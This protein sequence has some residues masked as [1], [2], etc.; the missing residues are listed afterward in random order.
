MKNIFL[1]ILF[2][3]FTLNM[4]LKAQSAAALV[5]ICVAS[6][7][8]D[9]TYLK[10][11]IIELEA[12][13]PNEKPP[14]AKYTMVLSKNTLYRFSVCNDEMSQG[15]AVIQL[16]DG[17]Q[18]L[19]STF[20]EATGREFPGFDFNCTKTGAYH[21]FVSFQEGKAGSSVVIMSFIKKI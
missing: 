19:G 8:E 2:T 16:F 21:I 6:A 12:A 11:F 7:G 10:D 17:N 4:N 18:L 3:L 13:K 14:V 1:I 15:R 5:D 9:A 20:N